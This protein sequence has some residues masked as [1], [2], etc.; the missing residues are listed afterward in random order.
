MSYFRK[1]VITSSNGFVEEYHNKDDDYCYSYVLIPGTSLL[2][3]PLL[4]VTYFVF[5]CFLFIGISIIADMFMEA[6]EVITSKV[7]AVEK[8]DEKS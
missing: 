7:Q 3:K 2:P 4:G 1:E 6:I 5:L 8:I